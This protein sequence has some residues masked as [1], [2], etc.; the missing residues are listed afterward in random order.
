MKTYKSEVRPYSR[1]GR[2]MR[3]IIICGDP[4]CSEEYSADTDDRVWE[5]PHCGR[6]KENPY[7]PFLT[8]R[9]MHAKYL[10]ADAD[11]KGLHDELLED[12]RRRVAD[13]IE[14][15]EFLEED[16]GKLRPRLPEDAEVVATKRPEAA[17]EGAFLENWSAEAPPD[18]MEAWRDLH[19]RLLEGA[20]L[21]VTALMDYVGGL[22]EEIKDLKAAI[23]IA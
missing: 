6:V 4:D 1:E 8:A 9:L 19:D 23:G 22:E 5:C 14:R 16:I 13:L 12:A 11:W 18:D 7:Y 17:G 10:P 2:S 21:Q 15:T 3:I 20:R